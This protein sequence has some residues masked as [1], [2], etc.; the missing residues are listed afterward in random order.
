[1]LVATSL[2]VALFGAVLP[3][4]PIGSYFGFVAP[5]ASFYLILAGLLT[6]SPPMLPGAR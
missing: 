2:G 6:F 4:A 5:P 3:F 1:V